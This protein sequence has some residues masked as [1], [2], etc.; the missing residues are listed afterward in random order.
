MSHQ[1]TIS[2]LFSK[3][4]YLAL[5]QDDAMKI[6]AFSIKL[7]LNAVI[8]LSYTVSCGNG[9]TAQLLDD[10]ESYIRERPDSAL[11]VLRSIDRTNL[12]GRKEKARF[13]LLH[14]MAIDKN[15]IDTTDLSIIQPAVD[16][17]S[18]HGNLDDRVKALYYLGCIQQNGHNDIESVQTL[19]YAW[20]LIKDTDNDYYKCLIC[21]AI[22]FIYSRAY[23]DEEALVWAERAHEYASKAGDSLG[24]WIFKGWIAATYQSLRR[25]DVSD[26][27]F[28]KFMALPIMDS[29]VY[30]RHMF[31]YAKCLVLNRSNPN[32]EKAI[33][34][35]K[36]AAS[37]YKGKP[38]IDDYYVYA[39]AMELLH[40]SSAADKLLVRLKQL[41][42]TG[43]AYYGWNYKIH[44]L[45]G[46]DKL[47]L[48]YFEKIYHLQDSIIVSNLRQSLHKAQRDFFMAKAHNEEATRRV[49]KLKYSIVI[50][51]LLGASAGITFIL[52]R[53]NRV[54]KDRIL[55][56]SSLKDIIE[57]QLHEKESENTETVR[58]IQVLRSEYYQLYKNQYIRLD[59]LCA[60]YFSPV[61]RGP[62]EKIYESVKDI[63]SNIADTKRSPSG[64]EELVNNH[65]NGLLSRLR[66]EGVALSEQD[67]RLLAFIILGFSAKTISAIIGIS[68]E[69]VYT[70]KF[71]IKATISSSEAPVKD[72]ILPFL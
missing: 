22:Y 65:L 72:E 50:L 10:V 27:L 20:E 45:R 25:Y 57:G 49:E 63:L 58:K 7:L 61:H 26:S 70:R 21:N 19:T 46:N 36:D 14:A 28:T 42:S 44:K 68:P 43:Q 32:P 54:R 17:Y 18:K 38:A 52:Y 11:N 48:Y 23:N 9:S 53:K 33:S 6:L 24:A 34:L 69:N 35:F 51:L 31:N 40:K 12:S 71:R 13:S 39:Y 8:V 5:K 60:A 3:N 67:F 41:D 66:K 47:A 15:F 37:R 4:V 64:A 2:F 30:A 1:K 56:L 55:E 62:K 29:T 16:Y 59:E